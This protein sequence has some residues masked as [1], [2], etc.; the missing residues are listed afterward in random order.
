MSKRDLPGEHLPADDLTWREQDILILLSERLTNKEIA[1]RL[2]LA[3]STIKDYVG[4]ILSKLY[5]KNRRQAVE[6]ARELGLLDAGEKPSKKLAINLPAE[7]TPFVG[8]REELA[9]IKEHL[10]ATR[11]LTLTGPGGIG[12]TRL[13]IKAAEQATG[14][15]NDGC[16]FVPLAPLRSVEHITQTIAESI[17]VPL[18]TQEDPQR[19]LLRYLESRQLL[20][21]IDNF[22][23]L[24]D[25]VEIVSKILQTAPQ[26]KVLAA[27]RERLNLQS[28]MILSIDGMGLNGQAGTDVS[29]G[30]DAVTLFV[31][32]ARKVRPGF[33]PSPDEL[34]QIQNICQIV[35]GMPLA[36]ELAA[37]WLNMLNVNEIVQ[38]LEKGL[39]ILVTEGRD[40]PERHRS[41]RS[42][43]DYSWS[44][45]EQAEQ[46]IFMQLSVFVGG[47]T[48]EAAQQVAGASLPLL[49]GFVNKSFLSHDP[50]SG[51]LGIH[52]LLR[53]YAQEKL[54]ENTKAGIA[55]QEKHAAYYAEF[56]EHRGKLL[57]G[58]QQLKA[59]A[60]IEADIENIRAAWR[61][62]L[63]QKNVPQLQRFMMGLWHVYWIRWWNHAGAEMFGEA[64]KKL[65]SEDSPEA[66]MSR[67]CAM[68]IQAYFMAW[69]GVS[70]EGYE[71][72]N[73]SVEIL[74]Q[75]NQPEALVLALDSLTINAYMF[76]RYAEEIKAIERMLK[77]T[78]ELDNKWLMAFGMFAAGMCALVT[79]NYHEARRHA[80]YNLCLYEEIGDV[81]GTTMPLIVLGHV[82]LV[83]GE[84]EQARDYYLRSLNT[85]EEVG[86]PYSTQT[87]TKYL[88]KV[89]VSLGKI[90][91][92]EKYFRKSLLISK[93]I[94]FYRDIIRLL[95][96]FSRLQVARGNLE[97]AAEIL[98]MAYHHPASDQYRWLEGY[99]RDNIKDLLTKIEGELPPDE[100]S[101]AV[102]RGQHLDLDQVIEELLNSPNHNS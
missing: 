16:F 52:E 73:Q 99:Q 63:G 25:G 62:Y 97:P 84:L 14:D 20:L 12:K 80:E 40:T 2:H 92:A 89:A 93:E 32:S 1:D 50:D 54:G 35:E 58:S 11:L 102:E 61:Y 38:E 67:G 3:E 49:A 10:K 76:N 90:E 95:Y 74:E 75:F 18:A 9:E 85:A 22:E 69:L 79:G 78:S 19:Q 30:S 91:E 82:A 81:I 31:Q 42:V 55:V 36:I 86:F 13:A 45:M 39:D 29:G 47:F 87:A 71:L 51:R 15:F 88:V 8:R 94:G 64:A 72:A 6:R 59:L 101:A 44:L 24:L 48:R 41:I 53:Q 100:F 23:H 83:L 34:K 77:I 60:E 65:Q 28:E 70:E 56:I 37:A 4:K 21:V 17:K 43:F 5:V 96:E 26:V 66:L 7:R 46:K 57:R 33:E 98:A 27:S 68:A